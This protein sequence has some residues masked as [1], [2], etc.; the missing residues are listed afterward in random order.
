MNTN[1][2]FLLVCLFCFQAD[3]LTLNNQLVCSFL[4]NTIAPA[5]SIP[6]VP[7][8]LGPGCRPGEHFFFKYIFLPKSVASTTVQPWL[9][10]RP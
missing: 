4:E 9:G 2:I 8:G 3:H 5:L 10:F 7:A 1:C 6:K